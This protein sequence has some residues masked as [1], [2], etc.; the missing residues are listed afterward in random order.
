VEPT[1]SRRMWQ[2][3]EPFHA[4][5]Y[6][7]PDTK[8]IY[9][10][11]GLK[12]GWM[13]YFAS[14]SAALGAAEPG[15]VTE[16]FYNF[17]PRMVS[18]ALPD[19]W[20]FSTPERVL[21]ARASCADGALRR[22]LGDHIDS[23]TVSKAGSL[24]GR[25]VDACRGEG[26][27]LFSAH[28]CLPVPDDPHLRLWHYATCLREHR[29]DGHVNALRD[30]EVDGCE[31]NVLMAAEGRFDAVSQQSFRGWSKEEWDQ[32]NER[33]K[34]RGLIDSNDMLTGKGRELRESIET[35]TDRSALPP[36]EAI[37]KEATEELAG[38]MRTL[39]SLVVKSSAFAFPNPMGLPLAPELQA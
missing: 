19:A 8:R 11:A 30:H 9:E 35:Q 36:W 12:G 3:I 4:V 33:L 37:G 6:F 17:N 31:A 32:A 26:R 21:A 14:R 13:G 27:P 23:E 22:A 5:V 1:V 20:T 29:G 16:L 7:S 39:S 25:A 18:R 2:L 15:V 38:Y 10:K 34:Q 24:A 28:R